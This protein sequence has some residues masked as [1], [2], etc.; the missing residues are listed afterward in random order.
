MKSAALSKD[1]PPFCAGESEDVNMSDQ[2]EVRVAKIE[3]DVQHIKTDTADLRV[4][5]RR[6]NEKID[7]LGEKFERK[8]DAME[9][10]FDGKFDAMEERFDGKFE[11]MEEKFDGK[12]DAME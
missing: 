9:E 12:F 6:T 2:L 3:S 4:E 8:F 10:R 1:E 5:L 7:A 11:A